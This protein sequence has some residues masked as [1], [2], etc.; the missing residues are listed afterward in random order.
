MEKRLVL[1][2]L[3]IISCRDNCF[4]SSLAKGIQNLIVFVYACNNKSF[5]YYDLAG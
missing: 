5:H 4:I 1:G 3:N 2:F